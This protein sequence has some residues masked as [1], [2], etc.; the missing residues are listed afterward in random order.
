[1]TRAVPLSLRQSM[2]ASFSDEVNLIFVTLSH[3]TLA[4]PIRVVLDTKDYVYSGNTFIGFPFDIQ[5]LSDDEQP[6]TAKLSFQNVDS[7][8]G[9]AVRLL[10]S[11]PRLKIQ[12]LHS[13]DFDLFVTP[14]VAIGTPD[15]ISLGDELFLINIQVTA[16]DVSGDIKGW[17]Y[18]QRVYPGL[19]VTQAALPGAFR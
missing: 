13:D 1:M 3:A 12:L 15:V 10:T 11:P 16:Q 19:R 4:D 2:E 8:I 14:R 5:L 7:E 9:H 18:L 17:D 6:P